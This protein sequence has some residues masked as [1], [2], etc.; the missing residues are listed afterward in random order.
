MLPN[1]GEINRDSDEPR[2][3]GDLHYDSPAMQPVPLDIREPQTGVSM[4]VTVIGVVDRV[5]A[6]AFRI[7]GPE[8]P[9]RRGPSLPRSPHQLSVPACRW[10]KGEGRGERA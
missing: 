6:N 2:L 1:E 7:F 10:S 9:G 8:A 3:F 5:H 4:E